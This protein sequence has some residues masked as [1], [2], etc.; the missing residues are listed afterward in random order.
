MGEAI[1]LLFAP[2][3]EG[4]SLEGEAPSTVSPVRSATDPAITTEN[5]G[6]DPTPIFGRRTST[7]ETT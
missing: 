3:D 5:T 2:T 1:G 6:P 4:A 7:L